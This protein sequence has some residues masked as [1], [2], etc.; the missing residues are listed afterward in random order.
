MS[1]MVQNLAEL[2]ADDDRF[3][4]MAQRVLADRDRDARKRAARKR[5]AQNKRNAEAM[6]KMAERSS[7]VS[8]SDSG[9]EGGRTVSRHALQ[10]GAD[11]PYRDSACIV[12]QTVGRD[13][14]GTCDERGAYGF[15]KRVFLGGRHRAQ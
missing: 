7:A 12:C 6:R 10:V 11:N 13:H 3:G 4:A 1:Q 14:E 9:A 2:M 5:E 8:A 15:S